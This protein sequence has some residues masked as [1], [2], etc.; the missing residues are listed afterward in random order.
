MMMGMLMT[1]WLI[2]RTTG[3]TILFR[4]A[5]VTTNAGFVAAFF[6]S[7]AFGIFTT[8]MSQIA[9]SAERK[10]LLSR[11]S[12]YRLVGATMHSFRTLLHYTAMLI[13]MTMQVYI[14]LAV[15]AGHGVGWILYAFFFNKT[16]QATDDDSIDA[17]KAAIAD[18]SIGCDC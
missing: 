17:A 2:T 18:K 5:R 9:K 12:V 4:G 7:F 15:A 6:A 11:S 8:I 3:F 14:I 10:A 13:V 1:P 16:S